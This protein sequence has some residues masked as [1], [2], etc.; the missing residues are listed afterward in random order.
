[1]EQKEEE[2]LI[3]GGDFNARIGREGKLYNG[4]LEERER[5]GTQRKPERK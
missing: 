5:G 3:I 2:V 4:E 1:M